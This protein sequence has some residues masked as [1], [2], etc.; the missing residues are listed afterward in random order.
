MPRTKDYEDNKV[1]MQSRELAVR[2]DLARR[3]TTEPEILYYLTDDVEPEVR[4]SLAQN[5]STPDKANLRLAYD[6]EVEIRIELARKICRLLPDLSGPEAAVL[7]EKTV[8]VLEILAADQ[9]TA[10]RAVIADSLKHSQSAPH[11]IIKKLARDVEEIVASPILE[12]SPLLP[13]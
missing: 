10:V 5:P 2:N 3:P 4:K 9:L 7:L 8:E 11:H 6:H 1:R 13:N 12:Y